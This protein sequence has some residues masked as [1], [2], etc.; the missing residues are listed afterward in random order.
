MFLFSAFLLGF[1]LL[2]K[3][4][5]RIE[6]VIFLLIFF[7]YIIYLLKSNNKKNNHEYFREF[8][9]YFLKLQYLKIIKNK[10]F[11]S[12]KYKIAKKEKS[13]KTSNNRIINDILILILSGTAIV[14][15]AKYFVSEAINFTHL[16]SLPGIFVGIIMAIGTTMPELSVAISASKKGQG[17]IVMGNVIG[18]CITNTFLILGVSSLIS[19]INILN[20]TLL[21]FVPFLILIGILFLIFI[22]TDWRIRKIEGI[23]LILCYILFLFLTFKTI[24]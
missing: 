4:L 9:P 19:K 24:L 23:I 20:I 16:F 14:F 5:S 8:I 21:Y 1:F 10:F 18:S 11:T 15:G 3:T 13:K 6:G 12:K 2:N 17:N 22:R 7:A